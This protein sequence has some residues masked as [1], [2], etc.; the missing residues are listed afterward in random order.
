MLCSAWDQSLSAGVFSLFLLILSTFTAYL[1]T[2]R[3]SHPLALAQSHFLSM[4]PMV[5]GM[6]ERGGGNVWSSGQA[7]VLLD[8]K[9]MFLEF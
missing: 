3:L 5:R 6:E 9:E 2:A 7:F 4:F 1:P 8:L